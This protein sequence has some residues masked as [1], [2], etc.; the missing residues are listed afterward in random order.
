MLMERPAPAPREARPWQRPALASDRPGRQSF[1]IRGRDDGGWKGAVHTQS[2]PRA[3]SCKRAPHSGTSRPCSASGPPQQAHAHMHRDAHAHALHEAAG[4]R[5]PARG[6][7]VAINSCRPVGHV[8]RGMSKLRAGRACCPP[9]SQL[10]R[11]L[12]G[13]VTDWQT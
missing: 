4:V 1:P 2:Q 13:T 5:G 3:P 9:G 6:G 8:L 11:R 12:V 7:N 10:K